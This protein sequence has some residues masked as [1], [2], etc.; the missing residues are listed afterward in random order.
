MK[1]ARLSA[2]DKPLRSNL[3]RQSTARVSVQVGGTTV[4]T[5][6]VN[7]LEAQLRV[8]PAV[9]RRVVVQEQ[10]GCVAIIRLR[11]KDRLEIGRS[12]ESN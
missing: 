10:D 5:S 1:R 6:G 4:A 3:Y 12:N 9:N 8:V 2:E 7:S 11:P